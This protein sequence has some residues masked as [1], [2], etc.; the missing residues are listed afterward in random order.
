MP[1]LRLNRHEQALAAETRQVTFL[2]E[3]DFC[4][5]AVPKL[6]KVWVR[7]SE[8]PFPGAPSDHSGLT[9]NLRTMDPELPS[10]TTGCLEGP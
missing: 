3:S 9:E 10:S 6:L 2:D 5:V 4:C 8:Y 7:T 1:D